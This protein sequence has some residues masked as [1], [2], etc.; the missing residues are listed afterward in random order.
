MKPMIK[1]LIPIL[2]LL[3]APAAFADVYTLPYVAVERFAIT[4]D[5]RLG[6]CAV[7]L[8]TNTSTHAPGCANSGWVSFSCDGEFNDPDK[9]SQMFESVQMAGVLKKN[10]RVYLENNQRHNGL[11][12]VKRVDFDF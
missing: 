4:N 7:R 8:A 2:S 5:G 6:G 9:A 3:L 11:C 12:V 10:V 1:K